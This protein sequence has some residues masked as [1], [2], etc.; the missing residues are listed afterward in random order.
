VSRDPTALV[1]NEVVLR[2]VGSTALFY[3][4]KRQDTGTTLTDAYRAPARDTVLPPVKPLFTCHGAEGMV[5]PGSEVVVTWS[6][7]AMHTGAFSEKWSLHTTPKA[8]FHTGG[9]FED[10]ME[11]QQRNTKGLSGG[12]EGGKKKKP[13]APQAKPS[14]LHSLCLRGLCTVEDQNEHH[15]ATLRRTLSSWEWELQVR[16]LVCDVVTTVRTPRREAVIRA[17]QRQAFERANQW[18]GAVY[19]AGRY[20]ALLDLYARVRDYLVGVKR[21]QL[22]RE[23]DKA[24]KRKSN[25]NNNGGHSRQNSE[26]GPGLGEEETVDEE[27]W[28]PAAWDG[29]FQSIRGAIMDIIR[30]S[31]RS[32]LVSAVGFTLRPLPLPAS[33]LGGQKD[34]ASGKQRMDAA[35]PL[36]LSPRSAAS[37]NPLGNGAGE[38]GGGGVGPLS[39]SSD[40]VVRDVMLL[41]DELRA[42]ILHAALRPQVTHRHTTETCIT[43]LICMLRQSRS[44][45]VINL[46]LL[47]SSTWTCL[48]TRPPLSCPPSVSP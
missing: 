48:L 19:E 25:N 17:A 13:A 6:F 10:E 32:L 22:Q 16:D 42:Q 3:S 36:L 15:R 2:N 28:L 24:A 29:S 44:R 20:D 12:V 7:K 33:M 11:T 4:L 9:P 21:K 41:N 30:T 31:H 27:E 38:V 35:S 34:D 23:K 37:A 1:R 47:P 45:V 18:L 43:S 39:S 26:A 46:C 40:R 14:G 8:R 5:L